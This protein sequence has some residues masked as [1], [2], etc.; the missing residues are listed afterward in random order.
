MSLAQRVAS[1]HLMK[2]AGGT[3]FMDF[4]RQTD[5]GRAYKE[6][7]EE[8]QYDSGRGGYS[9]TISEKDGYKIRSRTPMTRAQANEFIDRDMDK[10][11]K[12]GP[13]FCVPIAESKT[14]GEKEYA[15]KVQ[16]KDWNEARE[17]G[18]E[19]ITAK[20]RARQGATVQVDIDG[21][22]SE[23]IREGGVP[24]VGF[25]KDEES[26]FLVG[27]DT[28]VGLHQVSAGKAATRKDALALAKK[29]FIGN[30]QARVGDGYQIQQV[31]K[32]GYVKKLSEATRLPTWQ[33][34]GT[35]KQIALGNTIGWMFYGWASS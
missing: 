13:A 1:R 24:K 3:T 8:A 34:V 27:E 29:S 23:K 11:D 16:A 30:P 22:K 17:K 33:V 21:R 2:T 28:R 35:R 25:V 7:R 6:L 12:W 15:V 31:K 19:A 5:A 4:S 20:G 18:I 14:M 26:Y 10:N 9:G 32:L